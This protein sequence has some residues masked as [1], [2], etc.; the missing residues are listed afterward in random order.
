MPVDPELV[1]VALGDAT[2][3]LADDWTVVEDVV[4]AAEGVLDVVLV[5]TSM[6]WAAWVV[7]VV[8]TGVVE[9]GVVEVVEA[10]RTVEILSP[11]RTYFPIEIPASTS[12]GGITCPSNS[13]TVTIGPGTV[14]VVAASR[15]TT[16]A[17]CL[18][19]CR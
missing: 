13:K 10:G 4:G 5:L 11:T 14:V 3:V 16:C 1:D 9:V 12:A 18:A 7:D 19:G 17:P 2:V 8:G 15:P 6:N